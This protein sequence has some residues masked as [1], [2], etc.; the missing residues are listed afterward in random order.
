MIV[1]RIRTSHGYRASLTLIHSENPGNAQSTNVQSMI[2]GN[3]VRQPYVL[4]IHRV[5]I[6]NA[7]AEAMV[8]TT[9]L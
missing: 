4:T 7:S 1:V 6:F 3:R 9:E 8:R 2:F 5:D